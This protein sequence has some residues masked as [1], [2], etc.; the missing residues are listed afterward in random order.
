MPIKVLIPS[1]ECPE[2]QWEKI[3][4]ANEETNEAT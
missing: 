2:G 1:A 3:D 4:G